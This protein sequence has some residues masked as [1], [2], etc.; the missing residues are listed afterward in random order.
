MMSGMF[1]TDHLIGRCPMELLKPFQGY[2]DIQ[3]GAL[4]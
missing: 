1:G 2:E 3:G 4:S